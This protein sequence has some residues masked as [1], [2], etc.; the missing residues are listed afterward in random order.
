MRVF[1]ARVHFDG[2][3]GLP[4][5]AFATREL[6]EEFIGLGDV[7][8]RRMGWTEKQYWTSIH[9]MTLEDHV[10]PNGL[11]GLLCLD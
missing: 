7:R 1:L 9:E 5:A 2:C 10:D 4:G 3:D 6:A 8:Y 11:S